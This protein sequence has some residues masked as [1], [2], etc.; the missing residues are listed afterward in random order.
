MGNYTPHAGFMAGNEYAP[1]LEV[2]IDLGLFV[3][4]GYQFTV[5]NNEGPI[6]R[7]ALFYVAELPASQTMGHTVQATVYRRGNEIHSPA[8]KIVIPCT[9]ASTNT[10]AAASAGTIAQSLTSPADDDGVEIAGTPGAATL[11]LHF[12]TAATN[13]AAALTGKR[14]LNLSLLYT[15]APSEGT[16][17]TGI[18]E[19]QEAT[20]EMWIYRTSD[21]YEEFYSDLTMNTTPRSQLALSQVRMGEVNHLW[22][23]SSDPVTDRSRMPWNYTRLNEFRSAGNLRIEIL[24]NND[25][26]TIL[27]YAA[28]EVTYCDENREAVAGF[29]YWY[30]Y[31]AAYEIGPNL[32]EKFR[33]PQDLVE[34]LALEYGDFTITIKKAD[35]GPFGNTGPSPKVHA[36]RTIDP[37]PAHPGVLIVNDLAVGSQPT[38]EINDLTPMISL[39]ETASTAEDPTTVTDLIKSSH[40][41]ARQRLA[42]VNSGSVVSQRVL[43]GTTGTW[44]WL[45]FWARH[46]NA[47]GPLYVRLNTGVQDALVAVVTPEEIDAMTEV[48]DGWREV[49][50]QAI[51][52]WTPNASTM[53]GAPEFSSEATAGWEVLVAESYGTSELEQAT[54]AKAIQQYVTIDGAD[55]DSADLSAIWALQPDDVAGLAVTEQT[56]ALEVADATCPGVNTACV[57]T[58]LLYHHITWTPVTEGALLNQGGYFEVQRQDDTMGAEE[59]ETIAHV[60]HMPLGEFD[61]YEARVGVASRYR[62]R[63]VHPMGFYGDWSAEVAHTLTAPGVTGAARDVLIF[64]SNEQPESNLAYTPVWER[65]PVDSFTFPEGGQTAFQRMYGRDYPVAFRP[66]E[67]GGTEFTRTL[68]VNAAAVT[69]ETLAAGFRS[70]RDLA[71]ADLSYVCVRTDTADRW[72]AAVGVPAGTVQRAGGRLYLASVDITEVAAQ[73]SPVEVNVCEGL[74]AAGALPGL[75]YDHRYAV[76]SSDPGMDTADLDIRVELRPESWTADIPLVAR[77]DLTVPEGWLFGIDPALEG[78]MLIVE[79]A[80]DTVGFVSDPIPFAAGERG[81]VRVVYDADTGGGTQSSAQFYTSTDGSVWTPLGALQ[82]DVDLAASPDVDMLIGAAPGG[83]GTWYPVLVGP[84]NSERGGWNGVIVQAE[85]RGDGGT[86]LA[87]PDFEAQ[88]SGTTEFTDAQGNT[89]AVTGGGTCG[90]GT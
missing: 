75:T 42:P 14:I 82:N 66:V 86:L 87:S 50:V 12:D 46:F 24:A 32:I 39:W 53:P 3:E 15:L 55:V 13:V 19:G 47:Q 62:V 34:G 52:P 33:N 40:V 81:W 26:E 73:P 58:G 5:T 37:F 69:P 67:R 9:G 56:Q 68:L 84:G 17:F 31:T 25:Y 7:S 41:F 57:P 18:E 2:P 72:L 85:V 45:R 29:H 1:L 60:M 48:V 30:N 21:G 8:R 65:S 70:L 83:R 11:R 80:L 38:M 71:W 63:A 76:A 10:N 51:T 59:W 49:T 35:G 20:H 64:T 79:T 88:A 22:N 78:L 44:V 4:R 54:Y 6:T 36:A 77:Y 23:A 28:L 90:A 16:L 89:W 27:G 43:G 61:D 74:A